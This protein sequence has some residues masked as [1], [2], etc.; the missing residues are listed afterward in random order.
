[1]TACLAVVSMCNYKHTAVR[2]DIE[3][4]T[5]GQ[6]EGEVASHGKAH[7]WG[8]ANPGRAFT[9]VR[10]YDLLGPGRPRATRQSWLLPKAGSVQK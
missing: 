7:G 10:I 2:K 8:Q 1:M 3:S 9:S 5:R 6:E 4:K